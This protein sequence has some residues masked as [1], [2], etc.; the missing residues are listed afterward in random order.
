MLRVLA[1]LLISLTFAAAASAQL[2]DKKALTLD[3]AKK[4]AAAA[5]AEATKNNWR[6]G[7]VIVDGGAHQRLLLVTEPRQRLPGVQAQILLSLLRGVGRLGRRGARGSPTALR[8]EAARL[9]SAV[10]GARRAR[11]DRD[12]PARLRAGPGHP[13][14]A[15]HRR[16]HRADAGRV[17]LLEGGPLPRHSEV[18]RALRARVPGRAPAGGVAGAQPQR[19]RV[20]PELLPPSAHSRDPHDGARALV[21]RALVEGLRLRGHGRV[22]RARLRLLDARRSPRPRRLEDGRYLPGRRGLPAGLLRPVRPRRPRRRA[23]AC[24]PLRAE[25]P[26]AGR[27]AHPLERRAARGDPRA[28]PPLDPVDESLSRGPGGERRGR[29]RLREDRRPANLSLVQLPG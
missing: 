12:G 8:P 4:L 16:R 11:R 20:P 24:G 13:R 17:A 5:E 6:V 7:I 19:R 23:R 21:D 3:G 9:P 1:T 29:R 25:P 27:D 18:D 10:G 2:M 14:R 28:A 15:L 26:R 22:G